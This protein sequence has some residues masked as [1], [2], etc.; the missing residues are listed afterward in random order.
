[1]YISKFELLNYKSFSNPG[2]L[3]LGPKFNVVTGQNSAGK[4]ALLNALALNFR[5]DPHRSVKTVPVPGAQV[6][7][8]SLADVSITA[9]TSEVLRVLQ[10]GE[11]HSWFIAQPFAGTEFA[12]SIG[13]VRADAAELPRLLDN[14]FSRPTLSFKLRYQ[15]TSGQAGSWNVLRVPSFGL[16]EGQPTN[17]S[18]AEFVVGADLSAKAGQRRQTGVQDFGLRIASYFQSKVYRFS[19]ERFN[20]GSS[21]HGNNPVLR[22]DAGNLPEVLSILQANTQRFAKFNELLRSILPQIQQVSVRPSSHPASH[23]EII[24]WNRRKDAERID[25]ALPLS[26][27]GTW[28]RAGVGR[29]V[30][31]LATRDGRNRHY[32]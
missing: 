17:P 18:F 25:L 23:V 12:Q 26:E 27:C 20:L 6:S 1:M 21:P 11:P 10:T 9:T 29:S 30:R 4:T 8:L 19:A 5:S 3:T 2:P 32:R 15:T 24:V 16:Y 7:P 31:C 14:V 22:A 13:W 28:G